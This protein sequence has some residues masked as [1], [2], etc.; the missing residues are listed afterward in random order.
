MQTQISVVYFNFIQRSDSLKPGYSPKRP[1]D[2]KQPK[3]M[4]ATRVQILF[5]SSQIKGRF[6][7]STKSQDPFVGRRLNDTI[8]FYAVYVPRMPFYN[9]TN[10][11]KIERY[12]KRSFFAASKN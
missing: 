9:G 8:D 4:R 2:N 1:R 7:T 5:Y 10:E 11:V 3:G 12:E 6:Y